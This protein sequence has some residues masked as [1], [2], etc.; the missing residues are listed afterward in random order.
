MWEINSYDQL[1]TFLLS[2]CLGAISCIIYD[3]ARVVR[4]FILN[5]FLA[6]TIGD[7]LLW[8]FYSFLT[9]I[10]LI[11]RT[12]GEVRGYVI[13][14]EVLGFILVR[15]SLSRILFSVFNF[16]VEKIIF[17]N[18]I[19]YKKA[20]NV[21]DKIELLFL[22]ICKGAIKIFKSA[23][24]VLKNAVGLLYTNKNIIN[25]EKTSDETTTKA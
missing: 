18:R 24:K 15:V 2:C 20:Y 11:V 8:V 12:N 19:I 10:F 6:I 14:G 25:M 13:I 21:Y 16:I 1:I 5:S 23:K 22:K 9:F 17:I 7:M 4:K 3:I